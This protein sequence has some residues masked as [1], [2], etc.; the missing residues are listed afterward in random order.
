MACAAR[1]KPRQTPRR[2]AAQQLSE[3]DSALVRRLGGRKAD[4]ERRS[5][6]LAIDEHERPPHPGGELAAD[7]EAET[8]PG[9]AAAR[10]SA[11]EALED[12]LPFVGGDARP[13]V[14]D[15]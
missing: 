11:L 7:R 8:E 14:A 15:A 5:R 2:S 10:A 4:R 1:A 9:I 3:R 12:E 13:G 6:A